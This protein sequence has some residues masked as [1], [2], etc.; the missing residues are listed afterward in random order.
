MQ[1]DE[2]DVSLRGG[3]CTAKIEEKQIGI[4]NLRLYR[5]K[6]RAWEAPEPPLRNTTSRRFLDVAMLSQWER[7]VLDESFTP[8][9]LYSNRPYHQTSHDCKN[10]KPQ[11]SRQSQ[12]TSRDSHNGLVPTTLGVRRIIG[13]ATIVIEL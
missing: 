5:R 9:L 2:G 11:A 8:D 6:L 3:I 1:E 13:F 10:I 7:S 12:I 4:A